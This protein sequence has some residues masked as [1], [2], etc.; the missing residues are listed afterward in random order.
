MLGSFITHLGAGGWLILGETED[1]SLAL[2]QNLVLNASYFLD[3]VELHKL[4]T[5]YRIV[6]AI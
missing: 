2:E 5:K 3:V 4:K 1:F 6:R